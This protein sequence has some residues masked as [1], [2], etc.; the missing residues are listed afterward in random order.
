[1][2]VNVRT[3][4]LDTLATVNVNV[5]QPLILDRSM[6]SLYDADINMLVSCKYKSANHFLFFITIHTITA[7]MLIKVALARI[8]IL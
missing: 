2:K 3:A 8:F 5:A 1:M 4:N 6:L 7:Y